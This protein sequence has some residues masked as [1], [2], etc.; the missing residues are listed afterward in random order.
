MKEKCKEDL[1][2]IK[3]KIIF[4]EIIMD[5]SEPRDDGSRKIFKTI[6][7]EKHGLLKLMKLQLRYPKNA[8][9]YAAK[10]TTIK[11]LNII[12]QRKTS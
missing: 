2:F 4:K 10:I 12:K 3:F 9:F 7:K 8:F 6:L 5:L 11:D 1:K